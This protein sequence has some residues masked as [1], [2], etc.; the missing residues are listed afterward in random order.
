MGGRRDPGRTVHLGGRVL[1]GDRRGVAAVQP[2]PYLGP[3]LGVAPVVR[4]QRPLALDARPD[5]GVRVR[6]DGEHRV[7]LGEHGDTVAR[8]EGATKNLPMLRQHRPVL[9]AEQLC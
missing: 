4:R 9:A 1:T 5:G 3:R 2:H 6:E 8:P 7:T